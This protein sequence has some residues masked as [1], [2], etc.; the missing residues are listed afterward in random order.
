MK[1]DDKMFDG[2]EEIFTDVSSE[3]TARSYE[4][5]NAHPERLRIYHL[6]KNSQAA[7]EKKKAITAE[8]KAEVRAQFAEMCA[9]DPNRRVANMHAVLAAQYDVKQRSIRRYLKPD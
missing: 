6:G 1:P 2:M 9:H 8:I 7:N 4:D 3:S 5:I